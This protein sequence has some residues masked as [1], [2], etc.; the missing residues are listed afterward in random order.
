MLEKIYI[1]YYFLK[2][3]YEQFNKLIVPSRCPNPEGCPGSN[4][5]P[6]KDED[7]YIKDY[8]EIKIQVCTCLY[9]YKYYI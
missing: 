1:Y 7:Q 5:K 6:L 4:L 2:I 9:I 3:D 8:Q